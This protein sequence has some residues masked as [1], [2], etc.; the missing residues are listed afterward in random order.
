MS[1]SRNIPIVVA[2]LV[3]LTALNGCAGGAG[4]AILSSGAGSVAGTGVE[5]TFEGASIKTYTASQAEVAV[6]VRAAV[7][8]MGFEVLS[9]TS[10]GPN[11]VIKAESVSRDVKAVIEP[12]ASNAS[13]VSVTVDKGTLLSRDSATATEIVVQ[14]ALE[15]G[16]QQKSTAREP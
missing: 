6:A 15:I 1:R 7:E 13:R 5:R 2:S 11:R 14:T 10:D 16:N 4:M 9:E 8:R 12:V 3:A